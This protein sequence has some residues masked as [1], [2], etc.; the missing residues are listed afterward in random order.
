MKGK[1][2]FT[3]QAVQSILMIEYYEMVFHSAKQLS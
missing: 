3:S 1:K 2:N